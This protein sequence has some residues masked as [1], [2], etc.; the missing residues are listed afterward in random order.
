MKSIMV[1]NQKGGV[2]K[3]TT[4]TNLM[5]ELTRRKYRVLGVDLDGQGTLTKFL[6]YDTTNQNTM[7]EIIKDKATF[8]ETKVETRYG[9]L[10]PADIQLQNYMCGASITFSFYFKLKTLFKQVERKYDYIIVDCPPSVNA[11]TTAAL[12]AINYVLVPTMAEKAAVDGMLELVS[13]IRAV[14]EQQN[15]KIKVLGL[16]L[17]N[18]NGRRTL[19]KEI[20]PYIAMVAKENFGSKLFETKIPYLADVPYSQAQRQSLYDYKPQGKAAIAYSELTEEII[21]EIEQ[22]GKE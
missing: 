19:T 2:G 5:A 10:L 8:D 18:W 22:H 17:T 1:F 12:V 4:A 9:D 20:E 14:K 11:I 3:S 7:L 21:K 13:A 15:N 6:G 16:F